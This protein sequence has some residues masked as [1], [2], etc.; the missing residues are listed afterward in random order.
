MKGLI[1]GAGNGT[2]LHPFTRVTPKVLLLVANKPIVHY[3][4]EK[5]VQLGIEEIGIVIQPAQK[6]LFMKR[7]GLGELWGVNIQYIN[8][9]IPK[10]IA[11]AIKLAER[12]IENDAFLLLLGDN[13]LAESLESLRDSVLSGQHDAALLLGKVAKP[14]DYGIAEIEG[15]KIVGLEEK[16]SHPKTNLAVLGA[17]AFGPKLFEAVHAIA[18][19]QRGE[20]EITD[21]LKWLL[22]ENASISYRM[23][24]REHS[25]VGRPDRWLSTNRWMLEQFVH[26]SGRHERLIA[27]GCT[28]I[29]PVIIDDRAELDNC[30]IGPYVSIGPYVRLKN[31]TVKDSILLEG[32]GMM[33]KTIHHAIISPRH[34]YYLNR[35]EASQ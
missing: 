31:C 21:A 12:F 34:S 4:I 35:L 8:Q 28:I 5:L 24:E 13:M 30:T 6:P 10:G 26:T 17:Y 3:C 15:D 32:V 16:P 1:L 29:G 14:Q 23:T 20:Y 18:P 2:R 19:S 22:R 7:V 27:A 25:D 11:D 9:Y 33:N